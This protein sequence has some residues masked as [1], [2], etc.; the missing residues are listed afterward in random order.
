MHPVVVLDDVALQTRHAVWWPNDVDMM[1]GIALR[2]CAW[3]QV[4][5]HGGLTRPRKQDNRHG[6]MAIW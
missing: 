4:D 6:K 2:L 5:E 1:I 3:Q